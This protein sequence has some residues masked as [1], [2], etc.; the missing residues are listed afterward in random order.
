VRSVGADRTLAYESDP[1]ADDEGRYDII[2]DLAGRNS[3]RDCRSALR[4]HGTLVLVG[5]PAGR[6]RGLGRPV[7]ALAMGTVGH[8]HM[9]PFLSKPNPADLLLLKRL[10]EAEIIRPIIAKEFP[11]GDG[12]DALRFVDAGRPPGKVVVSV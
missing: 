8:K 6:L 9:R 4:D 2:L 3:L 7:R 1:L 10:A 12:A 11:F 5:G